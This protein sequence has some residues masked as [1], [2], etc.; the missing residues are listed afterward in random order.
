MEAVEKTCQNEPVKVGIGSDK[1]EPALRAAGCDR[2]FSVPEIEAYAKG[3]PPHIKPLS[4]DFLFRPE[5]TAV[6]VQPGYLPLPMMRKIIA[7]GCQWQVPGHDPVRFKTDDDRAKWRRQKPK[8]QEV[9]LAADVQGRPPKWPI[10]TEGQL[11]ALV[12][13]WHSGMK[14][15]LVVKRMQRRV[16]AEVPASWCRDQVIKATGSAK[17]TP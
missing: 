13:D 17:R 12:A 5:D 14:R 16:G 11:G 3:N 1:Q 15:A 6:M 7:T 4:M 9:P 8:D 2:V 10:P